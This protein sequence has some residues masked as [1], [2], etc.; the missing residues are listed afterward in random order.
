MPWKIDVRPSFERDFKHLSSE[1][2]TRLLDSIK[3]LSQSKDPAELGERL[4]GKW[5]GLNKLRI[6]DYRIIYKPSYEDRTIILLEVKHRS[7]I[8][9]R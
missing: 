8:Y 4:A 6:G 7:Q 5:R 3:E 1:A 9:Q 2:K